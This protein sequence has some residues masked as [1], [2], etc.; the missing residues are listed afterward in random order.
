MNTGLIV[1][2]EHIQPMPVQRVCVEC[3]ST[4]IH[5]KDRCHKHYLVYR[6][7]YAKRCSENPCEEPVVGRGMCTSHY[8]SW[9][10]KHGPRCTFE[11][12]GRRCTHYLSGK[13]LCQ[14]HRE[15]SV[16]GLPM[17]HIGVQVNYT[18]SDG[19]RMKCSF[20]NPQCKYDA[21]IH[22]LCRGHEGM[23]K[24]GETLRSL[25]K[26]RENWTPAVDCME[27]GCTEPARSR[28]RCKKCYGKWYYRQ[29]RAACLAKGRLYHKRSMKKK[30]EAKIASAKA[31]YG[32]SFSTLKR[33]Y[34]CSIGI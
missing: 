18:L 10:R 32:P 14:R 26:R 28:G 34:G 23:R 1:V 29:N 4:K 27:E 5:A 11:M 30:R 3:D 12:D 6:R 21:A 8:Q 9:R 20:N 15:M 16:K 19:T 25:K 17:R 31:S 2:P 22:G 33:I 7:S 13:G 24:R